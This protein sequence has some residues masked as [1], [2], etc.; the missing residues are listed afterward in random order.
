M[1][2]ENAAKFEKGYMEKALIIEE[3]EN[4]EYL[5]KAKAVPSG[6]KAVEEIEMTFTQNGLNA[7]LGSLWALVERGKA[8]N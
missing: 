4:G 3:L 5:V 2:I 8:K 1:K 7:F 6:K